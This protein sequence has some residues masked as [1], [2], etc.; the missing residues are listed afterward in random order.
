MKIK[1]KLKV[2]K[3]VN[4]NVVL[5]PSKE[6]DGT[7]RLLSLNP[8]SLFLWEHLQGKDFTEED[9]MQLLLDNYDVDK[10]RV[11]ADV[12]A[13]VQQLVDADVLE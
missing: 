4:E 10:E 6:N 7:T 9:A 5:L 12:K 11:I 3:I 13:W 1:S 2:R 8:T